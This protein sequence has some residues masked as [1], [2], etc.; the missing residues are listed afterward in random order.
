MDFD[1]IVIGGGPG[2]YNAAL[3]AADAGQKVALFEMNKTGG[4]CLNEGCIPTKTFL[5]SAKILSYCRHG[6]DY[7]VVGDGSFSLDH[8]AVIKRANIV[9]RRLTLGVTAELKSAGVSLFD[10]KAVIISADGEICSIEADGKIYTSKNLLIA[11]G[12]KAFVPRIEGLSE[13]VESGFAVT[14]C[15]SAFKEIPDRLAVTGGGA[16]GLES[17]AYFAAAGS[18]VTVIEL[19]PKIAGNFDSDISAVIKRSLE[20]QG[21]KFLLGAKAAAFSEGAVKVEDGEATKEIPCGKVLLAIGRRPNVE[22]FGLENTAVKIERGAIVT[23]NRMRTSVK[24]VWACGDVN[25]KSMLAHTAYREGEVA[26]ADMLGYPDEIDYGII[27]AVIYTSPEA[28]EVGI[29]EDSARAR[30]LEIKIAKLPLTYSGRYVAENTVYDGVIKLIADK[31][32]KK[33][34][35]ASVAGSYAGE[36]IYGLGTFIALETELERIKK[37]VFPHPTVSEIIRES[38]IALTK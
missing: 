36:I 31:D 30:G 29:N 12:S 23:D 11:S 5:N 19:L 13:A 26:V 32:G 6:K 33:L 3:K 22:G 10:K 8:A 9:I 38:I 24:G 34:L 18:D 35:G 16:A 15:A 37:I 17:A 25:G 14:G 2:G 7:G 1:L 21:I 20:K 27:P 28:A 4:V